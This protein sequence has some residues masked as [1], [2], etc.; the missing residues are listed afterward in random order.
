MTKVA[1]LIFNTIKVLICSDF[2]YIGIRA[3][4]ICPTSCTATREVTTLAGKTKKKPLYL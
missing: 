3:V 4:A 1:L 2:Y